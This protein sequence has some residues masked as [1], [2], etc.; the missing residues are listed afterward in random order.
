VFTPY[1]LSENWL[2]NS[3]MVTTEETRLQMHVLLAIHAFKARKLDK[4]MTE[5]RKKLSEATTPEEQ[6][7][8]MKT[9][10]E[11]KKQSIRINT[12]GL[13]RIITR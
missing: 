10:H 7:A 4:M 5:A 13:G 3:I 9:F 11:L 1:E 12:E 2:K 6:S 8:L